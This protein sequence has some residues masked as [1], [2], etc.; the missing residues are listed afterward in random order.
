M[1]R[2][3]F[4]WMLLVLVTAK[5]FAQAPV[6]FWSCQAECFGLEGKDGSVLSYWGGIQTPWFYDHKQAFRSLKDACGLNGIV[7]VRKLKGITTEMISKKIHEHRTDQVIRDLG[8][9]LQV[10]QTNHRMIQYR[11]VDREMRA[12][13][14]VV[15]ANAENACSFEMGY[16]AP[17]WS[18]PSGDPVH[19]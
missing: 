1:N 2:F 3:Q 8:Y 15:E 17:V 4:G 19:G 12:I 14:D 10:I 7:V 16:P 5:S 11:I 6:Q 13:F 18:T 9:G